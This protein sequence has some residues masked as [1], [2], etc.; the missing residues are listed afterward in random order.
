VEL[1]LTEAETLRPSPKFILFC[2][3]TF[4]PEA[5]KDIDEVNWP[6]VTGAVAGRVE[7]RV[8]QPPAS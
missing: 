5:A 2:A 4:D 3:F 6:G 8:T 1:A 7:I